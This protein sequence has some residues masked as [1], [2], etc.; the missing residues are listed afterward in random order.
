MVLGKKSKEDLILVIFLYVILLSALVAGIVLISI[1]NDKLALK[2]TLISVIS[3]FI[4]FLSYV[5]YYLY[6]NVKTPE[7]IIT[8]NSVEEKIIINGYK[9]NYEINVSDIAVITV[10]NLGMILLL[11]NRMEEGKLYFCLND[12]TKIKTA[13]IDDIYDVYGKLD[14]IIFKD[15]EYEALMKDQL[16]DKLDGWGAKKEYP[17]IVSI[18]VALFIP[19]FGLW[20]VSNQ[21]E[22][23]KLKNG[24]ATGLMAVALTISVFWGIAIIIAIAIL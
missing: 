21:M 20:F 4:I 1:F 19:F 11:A 6:K 8:Y 23:R 9:K 2:I 5:P 16:I 24:K 14:E 10:H 7:N 15:R 3:L 22:F 18:L 17:S 12:G 13:Y